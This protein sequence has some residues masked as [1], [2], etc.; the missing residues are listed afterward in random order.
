MGKT[1]TLDAVGESGF[2]SS[3]VYGDVRVFCHYEGKGESE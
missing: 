2:M 1:K 3:I